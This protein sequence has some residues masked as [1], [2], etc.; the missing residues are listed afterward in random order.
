MAREINLTP[1][2][3]VDEW[4]S[5]FNRGDADGMVALYSDDAI[6]T[7]PKLRAAQPAS[8][9]RVVGKAAMRRW[10]QDAFDRSPGIRYELVT[11]VSND[12][13]ATIEYL[14]LEPGR[15]TLRV[16]EIFEIQKGKIVRSH[17]FHG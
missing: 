13:V 7:S 5:A 14:R 9:G 3:I 11:T 17:V 10:W 12:H 4:L 16:A 15:P 2:E 8:E 1:Q 6:H